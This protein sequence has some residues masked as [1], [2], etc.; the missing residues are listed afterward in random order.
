M[1]KFSDTDRKK[2]SSRIILPDNPGGLSEEKLHLLEQAVMAGLDGNYVTCLSGWKIA[3]DSG[4]SRLD[5][6]AMID[7][8][9]IRVADC[10]LGCFKVNKTAYTGAAAEPLNVDVTRGIEALKDSDDLTCK[11][12]HDLAHELKITPMSIANVANAKGY[13]IRQCQLGCF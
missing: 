13:K 7:K 11:A 1:R 5:V 12:M 8:L 4:V 9:G 6:G 3:K 10:Q 2:K